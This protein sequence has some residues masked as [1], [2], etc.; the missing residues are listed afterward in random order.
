MKESQLNEQNT[1]DRVLKNR[2]V[3]A[4]NDAEFTECGRRNKLAGNH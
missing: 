1:P 4:H 2:I 3:F